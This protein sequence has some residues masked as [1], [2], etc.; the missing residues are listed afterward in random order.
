MMPR[1]IS[2]VIPTFN[3]SDKLALVL[4]ALNKQS[5]P[6][7]DYEVLVVDNNSQD[8]TKEVIESC[9]KKYAP[10]EIKYFFEKKQGLNFA[11]NC[12]VQQA[13]SDIVAFLDD[14]AI[15][16][17]DWLQALLS[18]YGDSSIGCVG[19]KIIPYFPENIRLPRWLSPI[20]NGYFSGFDPGGDQTRELTGKDS[21]PYGA[22]ISFK[23]EAIAL[24]GFFNPKLDRCGKN[25]VAGGEIE[26]CQKIYQMGWKILYN[27]HAAVRHLISPNRITRK[28]FF[29]HVKGEGIT[30]VLIDYSMCNNTITYQQLLNYI[31]DASKYSK[32][33][34]H[35]FHKE[36][37]RFYYYLR[38][39]VYVHALVYW[40][41]L[42]FL[43]TSWYESG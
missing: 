25:L 9:I 24:A 37:K 3:R 8:N 15:P 43:G 6:F 29:D 17:T 31:R 33:L 19:G 20:F 39:K 18:A 7:D 40:C 4:E 11:R 5:L 12:G 32:M 38:I 42:K 16:E 1:L 10:L 34:L 27:P 13:N 21:F 26:M 2:V 23:K 36:D 22:N 28:Y 14:D 35:T 41:K 30:K